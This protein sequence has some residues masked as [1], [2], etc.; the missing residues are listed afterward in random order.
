[1]GAALRAEDP[2]A[3][4]AERLAQLYVERELDAGHASGWSDEPS[5]MQM[6]RMFD[7]AFRPAAINETDPY[8]EQLAH[9]LLEAFLSDGKCEWVSQFAV[10]MPLQVIGRKLGVPDDDL[11]LIK[12]WTDNSGWTDGPH[13][14]GRGS[15]G[16]GAG[17]DRGATLLPPI[18]ERLRRDPDDTF[19]NTS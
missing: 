11:P 2:I 1:V 16:V 18:F 3:E 9:S 10:P 4:R 19:L 5:H 8:I 7:Q 12:N 13:A 6:R 15:R 17:R 14:D